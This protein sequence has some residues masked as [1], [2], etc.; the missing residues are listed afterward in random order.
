MKK[1]NA[2]KGA[3]KPT[4]P[5]AVTKDEPPKPTPKPAKEDKDSEDES[6]SSSSE[7]DEDEADTANAAK[8][9]PA[10]VSTAPSK[11]PQPAEEG[12]MSPTAVQQ[13]KMRSSSFR[14]GPLSPAIVGEGDTAP[15]IYRKQVA[16]I[17]DLERENKRLAK[18]A[19]DNE[20][21]WQKAED[22]LEDLREGEEKPTDEEVQK[23]VGRLRPQGSSIQ[24]NSL[25]R[26][27]VHL[28]I[29]A[30]RPPATEFTATKCRAETTQLAALDKLGRHPAQRAASPTRLEI[31]DH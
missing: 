26:H 30:C 18:E 15:D 4:T 12:L 3:A 22:E 23:L 29:R 24:Y 20:K 7:D 5:A 16:R 28:E 27:T 14:Q 10:P 17:E 8:K 1:K 9:I 2:K 13:S 6:S 25:T 11:S 31:S 19:A 21:R